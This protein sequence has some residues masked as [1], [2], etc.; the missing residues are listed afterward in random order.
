[1]E[2]NP[3]LRPCVVHRAAV[4]ISCN[5]ASLRPS[6]AIGPASSVWRGITFFMVL[7]GGGDV[8]PDDSRS[9]AFVDGHR[10]PSNDGLM[11]ADSGGRAER[12][13]LSS[14]PAGVRVETDLHEGAVAE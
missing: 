4:A 6:R 2:F 9:R 8:R 11:A 7:A 1:V 12:G 13:C 10:M 14:R 5:V 3:A